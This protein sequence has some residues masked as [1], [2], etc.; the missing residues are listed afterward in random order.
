[1]EVWC[2]LLACKGHATVVRPRVLSPL[3]STRAALQPLLLLSCPQ[4]LG[5]P[6]AN[7]DGES[8]RSA[9]A[10]AVTGV[11]AGWASLGL[12]PQ[13]YPMVRSR[14]AGAAASLLLLLRSSPVQVLALHAASGQAL[15]PCGSLLAPSLGSACAPCCR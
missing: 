3:Q 11:Y 5:I 6:T 12:S 14:R 9:L 13:V 1:M 8:L 2:L 7:V 4:E 15:A 10:E